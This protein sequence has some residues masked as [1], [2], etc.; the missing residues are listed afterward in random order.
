MLISIQILSKMNI[1][2]QQLY[3][4]YKIV[5]SFH[6]HRTADMQN[7]NIFLLNYR[8][9]IKK[10]GCNAEKSSEMKMMRWE[11]E[12]SQSH[13]PIPM[14]STSTPN[15]HIDR[16]NHLHF[17][18]FNSLVLIC[19]GLIRPLMQ[20]TSAS[21]IIKLNSIEPPILGQLQLIST[22]HFA[23]NSLSILLFMP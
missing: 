22:L 19:T 18:I 7:E 13:K 6:H 5:S 15:F 20:S 17:I 1:S 16:R 9:F 2:I 4:L 23:L 14:N 10:V 8:C 21:Q 11:C 12:I 3:P